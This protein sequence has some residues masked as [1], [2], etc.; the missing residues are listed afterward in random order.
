MVILVCFLPENALES[1]IIGSSLYGMLT[2]GLI[3]A[4]LDDRILPNHKSVIACSLLTFSIL[5]LIHLRV[6]YGNY[7]KKNE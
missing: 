3:R 1:Y 5:M 2:F 6:T 7:E 4:T